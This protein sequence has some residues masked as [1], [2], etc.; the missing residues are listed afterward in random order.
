MRSLGI[1]LFACLISTPV[2]A[3]EPS[4]PPA[5]SPC[6]ESA[7]R[8]LSSREFDVRERA[9]HDLEVAL[10]RQTEA[11]L[12]PGDP[13]SKARI[14]SLL[15]FNVGLNAWVLQTCQLPEE[16]RRPLLEFGLRA[17]MLP[18]VAK[19]ASPVPSIRVA[20]IHALAKVQDP[21]APDLLAPLL[22]DNDRSVYVAAME[23]AWDLPPKDVIVDHLW[24]RAVDA[25]FQLY[26]PQRSE[27]P[28][29]LFHGKVLGPTFFDNAAYRRMQDSNVATDVLIHVNAPQVNQ[30][31]KVFL[32]QVCQA[33]AAPNA[34]DNRVWMYGPNSAPMKNV[35]ALLRAYRPRE[36]LSPLYRLATGPLVAPINGEMNNVRYY[37]SNRTY[38]LAMLVEL[39]GQETADYKLARLSN[40]AG[41][42]AFA[43]QADEDAAIKKLQTWGESNAQI[44]VAADSKEPP[45]T[46]PAADANLEAQ[47][48]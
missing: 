27:Q 45:A 9:L 21:M 44:A 23:L 17:E 26:T 40:P 34:Q 39:T 22:E 3:A 28:D 24:D 29:V 4:T 11:M 14:T 33:Y 20:G 46:Q 6:I 25:G 38:P 10:G 37:W 2:L 41:I 42:W 47:G 5:L 7:L 12:S 43:D 48:Q 31:L 30:K 35:Y 36:A 18:I 19:L 8:E 1:V 32:E 15:E 16:Q 13:E